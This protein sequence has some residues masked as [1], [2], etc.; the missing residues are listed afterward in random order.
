MI[1][2]DLFFV[3]HH[4]QRRQRSDDKPLERNEGDLN[5]ILLCDANPIKNARLTLSR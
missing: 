4:R 5:L 2:I 1:F 3:Q